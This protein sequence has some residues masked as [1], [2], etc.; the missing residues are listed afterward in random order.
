[1][2]NKNTLTPEAII[3]IAGAYEGLVG[4]VYDALNELRD[5]MDTPYYKEAANIV[6]TEDEAYE[7]AAVAVENANLSGEFSCF[8]QDLTEVSYLWEKE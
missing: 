3:A 1:M 8:I 5:L 6:Y 4:K 7:E 2:K